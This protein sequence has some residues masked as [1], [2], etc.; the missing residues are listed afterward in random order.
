MVYPLRA[1][2]F[3]LPM[4]NVKKCAMPPVALVLLIQP[5]L[6]GSILHIYF[7]WGSADTCQSEISKCQKN[8]LN[9][10]YGLQMM[11]IHF[12]VGCSRVGRFYVVWH[13]LPTY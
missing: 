2:K 11:M 7:I 1:G 13:I 8:L 12:S 5:L 6:L 10:G 9:Y 3:G 4:W